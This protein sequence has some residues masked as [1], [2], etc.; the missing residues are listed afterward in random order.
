MADHDGVSEI[1]FIADGPKVTPVLLSVCRAQ[2]RL[3]VTPHIDGHQVAVPNE[4]SGDRV[5]CRTVMA[6]AVH[7]QDISTSATKVNPRNLAIFPGQLDLFAAHSH[8]L[9]VRPPP[10]NLLW[11]STVYIRR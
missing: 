6:A 8:M 11:P 3:T 10:S 2:H 1:E 5:P 4:V 9:F 7:Q